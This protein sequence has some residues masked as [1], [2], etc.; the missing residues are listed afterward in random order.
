MSRLVEATSSV[1]RYRGHYA[2]HAHDHAQLMFALE[3]RLE[4]EVGG[5]QAFADSACGVVVPAGA[6]HAFMA[7]GEARLLVIDAPAQAGIDRLRLFRVTAACRRLAATMDGAG[8]LA[9]ILGAPRLLARR[10]I[11]L[12]ALDA[13]LDG[14]LHE[15]W[16]TARM[17]ALF[18]L[19][20]QRFHARFVEL[21]GRTPQAHL[22]ARRLD[23][24]ERAL[25]GGT[26]LETV[27]LRVGYRTA[28]ALA[29]ALR[30][31]RQTGARRLRAR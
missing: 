14:S 10:G 20:P 26:P 9:E 22:R 25:A 27:A 6:E 13:A 29:M 5:R 7:P 17:A 11:D 30:R 8:Q 28:S 19:S 15:A 2:P 3:G 12:A 16:S 24:A 1:R 21:T 18:A 4:L 23:L 31:D